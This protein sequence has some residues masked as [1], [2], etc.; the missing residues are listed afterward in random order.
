MANYRLITNPVAPVSTTGFDTLFQSADSVTVAIYMQAY[1]G[2]VDG[3]MLQ[4]PSG[5]WVY[6]YNAGTAT[7]GQNLTP[8]W[9]TEEGSTMGSATY[10]WVQPPETLISEETLENA[11]ICTDFFR[12]MLVE[13]QTTACKLAY[14]E[15]TKWYLRRCI[16]DAGGAIADADTFRD[17]GDRLREAQN[18]N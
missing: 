14:L 5:F 6:F 2:D 17:F 15:E 7:S 13:E 12:D 8:G 1:T 9:Y 4:T 18:A 10:T 11:T 3:L 16:E